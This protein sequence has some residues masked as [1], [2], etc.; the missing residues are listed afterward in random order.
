MEDGGKSAESA[1]EKASEYARAKAQSGIAQTKKDEQKAKKSEDSIAKLLLLMVE[2][3]KYNN[4]LPQLLNLLERNI[5]AN[6]LVGV[7]S[8]VLVEAEKMI[9]ESANI[10]RSA[11]HLIPTE[12]VDFDENSVPEAVRNRINVWIEDMMFSMT[13]EAS[14]IMADKFVRLTQNADE[15]KQMIH[16]IAQIFTFFLAELQIRIA[17]KKAF[18]YAEFIVGRLSEKVTTDVTVQGMMD[19]AEL[20]YEKE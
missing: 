5:P 13:N 10:S 16:F 15:K 17:H 14:I 12:A 3:S 9:I 19:W 11:F 20:D 4:L 2:K 8:L 6:F 18:A 1:S 7:L